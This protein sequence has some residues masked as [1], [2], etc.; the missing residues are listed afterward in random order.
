MPVL[1]LV[2]L[3]VVMSLLAYGV[4][5]WER[6]NE[7]FNIAL[8]LLF[9][10][11]AVGVPGVFGITS[12]AVRAFGYGGLVGLCTGLAIYFP[13][14]AIACM[15]F[16]DV[17]TK[18]TVT[19]LFLAGLSSPAP[20]RYGKARK[21]AIE[22]DIEGAL[23]EFWNYHRRNPKDPGPLLCAVAMFE[24][25]NRFEEAAAVWRDILRVY[26]DNK[27]TWGEAALRLA[28]LLEHHLDDS[29]AAQHLLREIQRRAPYSEPGRLAT[30]RLRRKQE[31]PS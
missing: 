6:T 20:S 9:V 23:G 17:F 14:I 31:N 4:R 2:V 8:V 24:K 18:S 25:H 27:T 3:S 15:H 29:K 11:I 12:A 26:Q 16:L 30:E 7:S 28:D 13:P 5:K 19:G 1:I 22:G 10:V 21:R